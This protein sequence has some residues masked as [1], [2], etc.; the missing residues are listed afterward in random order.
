[1]R[2]RTA[3]L[4]VAATLLAVAC[5]ERPAESE[6]RVAAPGDPATKHPQPP[7]RP[8][9][10]IYGQVVRATPDSLVLQVRN[11]QSVRLGMSG[12]TEVANLGQA[13]TTSQLREGVNVRAAFEQKDGRPT[14]THVDIEGGHLQHGT[15]PEGGEASGH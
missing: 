15:E 1:M 10:T 5:R 9:G 6:P 4:A 14:A 3:A 13:A 12:D 7:G 2:P 11:G 8:S